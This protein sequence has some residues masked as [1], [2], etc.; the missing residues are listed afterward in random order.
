VTEQYS[1]IETHK[2]TIELMKMQLEKAET[3]R[4]DLEKELKD[5]K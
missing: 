1:E 3:V 2:N 4:K 5:L